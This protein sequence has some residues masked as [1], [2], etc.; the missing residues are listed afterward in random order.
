MQTVNA[1]QQD[2]TRFA[3]L[4]QN[5]QQHRSD[6][7]TDDFVNPSILSFPDNYE[8][9]VEEIDNA[10]NAGNIGNPQ[11]NSSSTSPKSPRKKKQLVVSCSLDRSNRN[12]AKVFALF[13]HEI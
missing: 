8:Q 11:S 4:Q 10:D 7:Y 13:Q 9:F 2:P 6:S 3:I 12:S 1:I 5:L